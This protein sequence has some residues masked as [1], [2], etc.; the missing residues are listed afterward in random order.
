MTKQIYF[1]PAGRILSSHRYVFLYPPVGYEFVV[2]QNKWDAISGKGVATISDGPIS[3]IIRPLLPW[4]FIK[5][6][7]ERYVKKPPGEA[8]LTFAWNH[9]VFRKEPWVVQVEWPEMLTGWN[10]TSFRLL[11]G[12]IEKAL[13]SSYCRKII[14]WSE[15]SKNSFFPNLD[16][17][18]FMHKIEVVPL[19]VPT[20]Q[21]AKTYNDNKVRLLF[22]GSAHVK[23][24]LEYNFDF[25]GGKE[26]LESFFIL[27]E[28]YDNLEFVVRAEIPWQYKEKCKSFGNIRVIDEIISAEQL[29]QEYLEADIFI[30][31]GHH[32]PFGV[33]LEAMSYELPVITTDVHGNRE[34][35]ED[36]VTGLVID[37]SK[38]VP[39]FLGDSALT[40][41]TARH[42]FEQGIRS[43]DT[44]VVQNLVEK[45]SVLIEDQELAREMGRAGRWVVEEGDHSIKKRNEKLKKI[46]DEAT[47]ER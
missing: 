26:T 21:F 10:H 24:N 12:R 46:C 47:C 45:T 29:E 27:N 16:C 2:P 34:L 32:T 35:V 23:G 39:Y 36:G 15:V 19:A 1:E 20:K 18:D 42:Q 28:K 40:S 7:A 25:K 41:M 4:H 31:P 33:I 43:L 37:G 17:T 5:G 8:C 9:V 30:F 22:V 6:Q 14:T 13:A 38:N 44:K 11:K 3:S